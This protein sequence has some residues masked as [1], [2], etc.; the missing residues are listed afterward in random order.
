MKD[1]R[2]LIYFALCGTE[3]QI[4]ISVS[5]ISLVERKILSV[6][7]IFFSPSCALRTRAMGEPQLKKRNIVNY[8]G[9][10]E[11]ADGRTLFG[12]DAE[13]YLKI[14]AKTDPFLERRLAEWIET[15]LGEKLENPN[16][17]HLSLKSG[18]ILCKF[19]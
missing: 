3:I 9:G 14:Q 13:T 8:S 11:T 1:S 16:D 6:V 15:L 4:H 12:L 5:V 10:V 2:V 19:F 17:L 7:F 18:V